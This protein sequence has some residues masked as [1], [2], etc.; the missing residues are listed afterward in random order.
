MILLEHAQ[1]VLQLLRLLVCLVER[2]HPLLEQ[3]LDIAL[4]VHG[5]GHSLVGLTVGS[6]AAA[7]EQR[8]REERR[9]G[10]PRRP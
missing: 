9:D 3:D 1:A 10:I 7:R 6:G 8:E 2:G 5:A 4:D